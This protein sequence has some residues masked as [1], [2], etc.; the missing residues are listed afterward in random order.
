M[1]IPEEV[2]RIKSILDSI[3]GPPKQELDDSL[4]LEYPCPCCIDKYGQSDA[5]K[6]NLSVS[7]LDMVHN[8][9][10]C[11]AE[12]ESTHG[13]VLKLIK[14]YG[15]QTMVDDFRSLIL[16]I[17]ESPLYRIDMH[18]G[19]QIINTSCIDIQKIALPNS[20]TPFVEGEKCNRTA[21]D[22][23][24]KRGIGW[25]II[26]KFHIGYTERDDNDRK[27]SYRIIIPSYDA[28]GTLNY[29]VGRDYLPKSDKFN[30]IKYDNPKV[31]KQ[32][33]VFNEEMVQWDADVTLVEGPFDHIVVPNSI[34]LLGKSLSKKSKL[35]N[36]LVEKSNACINL[37][38][39]DDARETTRYIYSMLNH[40]NL[41]GKIRVVET[42]FGKDPSEI[43]EKHGY[44]GIA[45]CLS[46]TKQLDEWMMI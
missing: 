29:W 33:I 32:G 15:S 11:S 28:L 16:S 21:L 37:W 30:R 1:I 17:R 13:S 35:Y 19:R 20:Y 9:W 3:L 46:E 10:K 45:R 6:Y 14:R 26:S 23:L 4:Q 44:K 42:E 36:D 25:D 41:Y 8:C 12:G 27:V 40:G 43:Y 22:Y 7:L 39:D 24:S 31:E 34:P 18:S 5:S 2:K 38:L